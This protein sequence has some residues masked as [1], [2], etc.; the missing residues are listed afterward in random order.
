MGLKMINDI[1]SVGLINVPGEL[2]KEDEWCIM[3]G[4]NPEDNTLIDLIA[5][6]WIENFAYALRY[7]R[8][9]DDSFRESVSYFRNT[10]EL[11][12]WKSFREHE[13]HYKNVETFIIDLYVMVDGVPTIVDDIVPHFINITILGDTENGCN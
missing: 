10:D 8:G 11:R 2:I 13:R 9:A 3:N 1:I 12:H 5:L 6:N 4:I 7:K